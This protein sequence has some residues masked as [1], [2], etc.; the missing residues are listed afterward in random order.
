[1][2]KYK[3][4]AFPI[5]DK[6]LEIVEGEKHLIACIG[7]S[8][9]LATIIAK[10]SPSEKIANSMMDA[11]YVFALNGLLDCIDANLCGWQQPVERKH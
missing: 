7:I 1:M 5:C 9:G 6:L 4:D 10:T 3:E 11:S 8:M 2:S